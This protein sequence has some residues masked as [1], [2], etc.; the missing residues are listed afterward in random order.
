MKMRR[1]MP[2]GACA[3][4]L[5]AATLLSLGGCATTSH[6]GEIA[7][8]RAGSRLQAEPASASLVFAM[9]DD[10]S[11]DPLIPGEGPEFNRNDDRLGASAQP[12]FGNPGFMQIRSRDYLYTSNGRPRDYSTTYISSFQWG[13]TR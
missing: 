5:A 6:H 8:R 7:D 13:P 11:S 1:M 10:T 3:A 2:Q 12:G 4:G 9:R